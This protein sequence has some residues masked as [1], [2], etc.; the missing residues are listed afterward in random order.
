MIP[1]HK[2]NIAWIGCGRLGQ[3]LARLTHQHKAAQIGQILCTRV[4]SAQKA[5]DFIGAGQVCQS[6]DL[7]QAHDIIVFACPDRLIEPLAQELALRLQSHP[8]TLKTFSQTLFIHNSGALSRDSLQAL[9]ALGLKTGVCHPP[10]SIP[11][12]ELGL[13]RFPGSLCTYDGE[14][15]DFI[16]MSQILRII[17]IELTQ[18]SPTHRTLYHAA[19]VFAS[20]HPIILLQ[21]AKQ[22]LI[23]SSVPDP[24]A[25]RLAKQLFIS[26]AHNLKDLPIAQALSGPISR[27]D[28]AVIE[29]HQQALSGEP[30]LQK[31]YQDLSRQA[32]RQG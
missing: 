15:S 32:R 26:V 12:V 22:L 6:L 14:E 13:Q 10:F 9:S 21:I 5:R 25:E 1:S 3:S 30:D 29:A 8:S 27:G 23:Q 31:L 17:G 28:K 16:Q 24:L 19:C 7:I 11:T 4:Q 2:L 20:N 18:L